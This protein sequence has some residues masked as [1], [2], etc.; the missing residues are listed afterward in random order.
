MAEYKLTY[1]NLKGLGESIRYIFA[2]ANV[3][4]DDNRIAKESWPALKESK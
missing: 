2:Y 3:P 4:F 1:F